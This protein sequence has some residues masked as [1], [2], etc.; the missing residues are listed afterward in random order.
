MSIKEKIELEFPVNS[1][2]GVLYFRL[3]DPSGLDEWFADKVL[4]DYNKTYTF[5]WGD[6]TAKAIISDM[7]EDEYIRF[8]WLDEEDKNYYLE[9]RIHVQELTEETA[10]LITDFTEPD[11][12]Q[13]SIELWEKQVSKLRE[14]LGV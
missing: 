13:S 1:S 8:K 5:I 11:E 10:L 12:K 3:S 14:V 9:F 7:N 2:P 6:V 4:T